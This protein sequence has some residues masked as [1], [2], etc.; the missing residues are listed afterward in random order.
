MFN[1]YKNIFW[2]IFLFDILAL[3]I[4]GYILLQPVK[5]K[6]F[7][8]DHIEAIV[9][10]GKF[11][12]VFKNQWKGW[13]FRTKKVSLGIYRKESPGIDSLYN[14]YRDKFRNHAI[15]VPLYRKGFITYN[16]ESLKG[17]GYEEIVVVFIGPDSLLYW[18]ST[19]SG[20]HLKR[21]HRAL[22]YCLENLRI[23]GVPPQP[24]ALQEIKNYFKTLPVLRFLPDSFMGIVLI[25]VMSPL[26][27]FF[28]AMSYG[29]TLPGKVK[30]GFDIIKFEE[31]CTYI[32]K[33]KM[34]NVIQPCAIVLNESNILKVYIFRKLIKELPKDE[35]TVEGSYIKIGPSE[36][37]RVKN[38]HE[39]MA[40][41]S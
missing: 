14:L 9:P 40:F 3:G 13:R 17:R 35:I 23:K 37:I 24:E 2:F 21:P 27:I 19:Y 33:T 1:S 22:I 36:S 39:W 18:I 5:Y 38:I 4:V 10:D 16:L 29:G 41:L 32:K 11:E 31:K 20:S 12:R 7:K 25:F 8:V 26:L 30:Q 34:R 15:N 28:I 6:T